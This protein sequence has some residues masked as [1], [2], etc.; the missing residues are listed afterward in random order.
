MVSHNDGVLI[1]RFGWLDY[2]GVAGLDGSRFPNLVFFI[3][4]FAVVGG[5]GL[6]SG[7]VRLLVC[8]CFLSLAL[9]LMWFVVV[10]GRGNGGGVVAIGFCGYCFFLF[11]ILM[12][13]LYYFK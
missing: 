3:L 1:S 12:N 7:R 6:R 2:G 4:V 9:S 5:C 10:V 13:Y 8:G 11:I